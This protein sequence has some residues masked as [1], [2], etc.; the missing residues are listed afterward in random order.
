LGLACLPLELLF[1]RIGAKFPSSFFALPFVLKDFITGPDCREV[2]KVCAIISLSTTMF[3]SQN[4][5][6]HQNLILTT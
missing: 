2:P 4:V 6:L 5:N 1:H 3:D